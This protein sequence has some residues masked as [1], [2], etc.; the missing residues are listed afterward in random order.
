MRCGCLIRSGRTR[1]GNGGVEGADQPHPPSGFAEEQQARVGS[2][3]SGGE[4]RK[5]VPQA[6]APS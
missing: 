2:D 4:L 1:F 5:Q 6:D 3:V